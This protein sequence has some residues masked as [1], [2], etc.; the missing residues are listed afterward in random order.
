MNYGEF[1]INHRGLDYF[2]VFRKEAEGDKYEL[3]S[4]ADMEGD[5]I[6]PSL[7]PG[8]EQSIEETIEA[9]DAD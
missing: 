2:V 4:V 1:E 5:E 6:D 7:I 3:E 8:L 9:W